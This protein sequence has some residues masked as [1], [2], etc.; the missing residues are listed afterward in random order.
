MCKLKN[1][2]YEFNLLEKEHDA[3]EKNNTYLTPFMIAES[4]D[5]PD[6]CTF[7]QKV[8]N[9]QNA[10]A[11]VAIVVFDNRKNPDWLPIMSDDGSGAGIRIPSM[12]ISKKSGDKLI[13]FMKTATKEEID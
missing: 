2:I 11:A 13:K 10:G 1:D 3:L 12:M 8:R 5:D 7:V 6:D 9:M 4:F